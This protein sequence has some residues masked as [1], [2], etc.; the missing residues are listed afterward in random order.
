MDEGL[1]VV[2]VDDEELSLVGL[3]SAILQAIPNSQVH[4]F[5][6]S[7]D[8]IQFAKTSPIDIAFL[9]ISLGDS[10]GISLACVIKKYHPNVNIIFV[11]GYTQ[12]ARSAMELHASGYI[13]KPITKEKII[14]EVS[15]LRYAVPMQSLQ[16]VRITTFGNF[17]ISIG[18]KDVRFKYAKTKELF[19]FL[20]DRR[21]A[22]CTNA[23]IIGILW[24]DSF[25]DKNS[26][27]RNLRQDLKETFLSFG[28]NDVILVRRGEMALD[29]SKVWCDYY[30]WLNESASKEAVY[31][32]EYMSQYSWAETTNGMLAFEQEQRIR[33]KFRNS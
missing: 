25:E 19:A 9:D 12:Y 13:L 33:R 15:D 1:Q 24:E 21:G 10:S 14:Q 4:S 2:A 23:S 30:E 31:R 22:F 20:V 32:G 29:V 6:C 17:S 18:G 16:P 27:L 11:T 28:R 26:Y 7:D 8:V 3:C 5:K